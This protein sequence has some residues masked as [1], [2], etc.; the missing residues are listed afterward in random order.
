MIRFFNAFVLFPV[1]EKKSG[2]KISEKLKELRAF[3]KKSLFEQEQTRRRAAYE[4]VA[5]A[6]T[7]VPYYRDLL[8]AQSFDESKLLNDLKYLQDIPQLTKTIVRE[9]SGDLR[10]PE[11]VHV[12]KTGGSTGQSVLFYYDQEGLDWTAAI[13]LRAYEMAGKFPYMKDS[14]ISSDLDLPSLKGRALLLDQIKMFSQNRK[15]L[16]VRSFSDHDLEFFYQQLDKAKP[17]LL[18]GHPSSAYALAGYIEKKNKP[19]RQYCSVFEPSGEMLTEK[20]VKSIEKNLQCKVVNR[21]GNAECG[22]MAHSLWED[23]YQRLKV[24]NRAFY[25]DEVDNGELVVTNFTNRSFPLIRY[26]TGDVGTIKNESTGSF[27]YNL[28]GRVHDNIKIG[29]ETCSTLFIMDYLD[30]HVTGIREFQICASRSGVHQLNIVPERA[31][32]GDRIR[33]AIFKR[34][35]VGLDIKFVA[36]EDLKK[37]GWQQKFRH[38]ISID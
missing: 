36:Y 29:D 18:Q 9:R 32:D 15:R 13:N 21:Y 17:Y 3:E 27:L 30:H 8:K 11:A 35:P 26:N 31:E 7:N 14:H 24:F 6:R 12:R 22:V 23:S 10:L 5:F 25:F 16:M 37:V 34:W 28:Q 20:M 38:I 19:K 4:L 1:L 33:N 2:R